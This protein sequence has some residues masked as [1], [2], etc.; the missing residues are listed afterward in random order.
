MGMLMPMQGGGWMWR[1]ESQRLAERS[2]ASCFCCC[3]P[4][5]TTLLYQSAQYHIDAAGGAAA[6]SKHA[7][8]ATMAN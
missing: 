4:F 3:I 7:E 6:S 5:S 2:D 1:G 8:H